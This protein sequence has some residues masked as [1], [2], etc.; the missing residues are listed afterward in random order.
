M[1]HLLLTCVLLLTALMGSAQSLVPVPSQ[2]Q[3]D[4]L[5]MERY[6]FIHFST[7]TFTDQEWGDGGEDINLF[8]PTELDCR[9]W[10]RVCKEGGLT[11]IIITAKHHAGFCLWPS[12]YTDYSV[13]N[14]PWKNGQGDVLRELRQACDEY[15]L[16]MGIYLSPW[17]RNRADYGQ[18]SYVEYFRN[19]VKELLTEYGDIFEVWFDG[20]NGGWGYYGG[21]RENRNIDR[22]TYYGW[23][24][25]VKLIR[26]LQP[27]CIIWNE[28]GPDVR[29]CGNELGAGSD[30][31][32]SRYNYS[33]HVPGQPDNHSLTQG[34]KDGTDFVPSEVNVSIRPG[35]FYHEFEDQKVKSVSKLWNIYL[36]SVGKN[37]TWL[38]NFPVDRRGLIHERDAEAIINFQ[39]YLQS[40]LSTD[41]AR[42]AKVTRTDTQYTLTLRRPATINLVQLREE[43]RQ[44]QHISQFSVE[45]RVQGQWQ[46]IGDGTTVGNKRIIKVPEQKVEAIR[47]TTAA[48]HLSSVQL[49]Y[50]PAIEET[51]DREHY[52]F[53]RSLWQVLQP[54][55]P[56]ARQM[57]DG[58]KLSM[59]WTDKGFPY[60]VVID[61]KQE[62]TLTGFRYLPDQGDYF[63]RGIVTNYEFAVSTDGQQ[64][65]TVS[66]GEFS[67]IAHNPLWQVVQFPQAVQARY[68][69]F[70][71]LRNSKGWGDFG[72]A[73]LDVLTTP[74]PVVAGTSTV[75]A[76]NGR[77]TAA[78]NGG[79][80]TVTD[81]E[82]H[83][84]ATFAA[85][86]I[87]FDGRGQLASIAEVERRRISDHYTMM[88]GKRSQCHNEGTE[89]LYRLTDD[90]GAEQL[91]RLR[92]YNDGVAFRYELPSASH[93]TGEH[94]TYYLAPQTTS[95]MQQYDSGYEQFY[96]ERP[97]DLSGQWGYPALF[98]TLH[99]DYLLVTEAGVEA[100]RCASWLNTQRQTSAFDVQ[101]GTST[102][103]VASG[104]STPWRV[105]MMGTLADVVEST[106][107]TDV[108]P[109]STLPDASWVQPGVVSWIYWA[110]NHG[111][112][113]FQL[114]KQYVDMAATLHLPYV[115]IDWEWEVMSN[116]G[117]VQDAVRYA[118]SQGVK[119]L[120]WYN[121]WTGWTNG[122]P[123]TDVLLHRESRLREFEKIASWGVAGVKIDF[124]AGDSREM[125]D[126]YIDIL[127]D[128]AQHH[129]LVNFHGATIPRGWQ[130]TYPHMMSAEAVYGAEWYNNNDR[131]T[132]RAARHNTTLPF[133]R[134][135][136][137]SMDYTPCAFSDSQHPHITTHA[138]ELALTVAFESGLQHLADRPKSFLAQPA[139]VQEFLGQ[140]PST[141]DDTRLLSGAPGKSVVIARRKGDVWF[142]A[143]LNGLDEEQTLTLPRFVKGKRHVTL[144][145]DG[146]TDRSFNITTTQL[147][148]DIPCRARGGFVAVVR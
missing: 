6:A 86:G 57:L 138:H 93:V 16:K 37:S 102:L 14:S 40:V 110:H 111:S 94:T 76:P 116:G 62:Q 120:L 139:A 75:T 146:P 42:K 50:A 8:N 56:A 77:F 100:G 60:D 46:H 90:N 41:F 74:T 52:A 25:T 145:A 64:W 85:R 43:L 129:L 101:W 12:K 5:G 65:Q 98:Q 142:V 80:F 88:T 67:N 124:F 135:V 84:I 83:T 144:F 11:G 68:F 35:W 20:A 23:P 27:N 125:M 30:T 140:L 24:E 36:A 115:L 10:A 134:N 59:Y 130:R 49:Y 112:K 82:K 58:N 122:A 87:Q 123:G 17:D 9:Q 78:C 109:A 29:W 89:C 72:C 13:K 26:Q 18:P 71:A 21:A 28:V 136:V 3:L 32:W 4:W 143:G 148:T 121:S 38:L 70:R 31:N 114:V 113:D 7:N 19:Q 44:G 73:E 131:L 2:S 63:L 119:P 33:A 106:L 128:A 141:W 91:L 117:N 15:G 126:Y 1:K 66:D 48:R 99:G 97:A 132:P 47:V 34:E 54:D 53:D 45:A 22:A 55:D 137:G 133:T 95:W 118:L 79:E 81:R 147:G 61:M 127:R 51:V 92:V 105:M 103:D 107:V 69:R 104:W 96:P 108:S 39:Y